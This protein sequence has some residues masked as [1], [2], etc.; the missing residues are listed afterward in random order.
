MS[1][2]TII[3]IAVAILIICK[4]GSL[5][6]AVGFLIKQ[7]LYPTIFGT[8]GWLVGALVLREL[9]GFAGLV[10][11]GIIGLVLTIKDANRKLGGR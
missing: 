9:G 2:T 6:K 11:G 4:T 7:A 1:I 5:G 10:I 8:I 3:V